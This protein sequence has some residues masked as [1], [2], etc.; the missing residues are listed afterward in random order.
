MAWVGQD[1]IHIPQRI[2]S[3]WLGCLVTSTSI[4][5]AFAQAPQDT[6]LS[7][8]IFALPY[9]SVPIAPIPQAMEQGLSFLEIASYGQAALHLPHLIHFSWSI[10]DLPST[11]EIAPFGHTS[12]H[13]C[14][15][16]PW[17]ILDTSYF[18]SSH[19]LHADGITCI[20]GGS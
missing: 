12:I 8:S 6:H 15:I 5:H 14:A 9:S 20:R 1:F 10:T 4:L 3:A 7:A 19:R 16:H 13:G 2:H 17:H 11:W 18:F